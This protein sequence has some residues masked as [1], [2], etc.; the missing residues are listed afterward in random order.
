MVSFHLQKFEFP[1][2]Q[3][4]FL[5]VKPEYALSSAEVDVCGSAAEMHA[6]AAAVGLG[7]ASA[8][9]ASA[10]LP[11]LMHMGYGA[12]HHRHMLASN[13]Q[14]QSGMCSYLQH[15]TAW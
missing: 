8:A 15:R 9:A 3:R 5:G 7:S 2:N 12:P 10:P 6:A 1:S 13:H 11:T 4:F 14:D